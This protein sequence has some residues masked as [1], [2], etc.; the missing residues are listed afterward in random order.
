[1]DVMQ[2]KSCILY[3][4]YPIYRPYDR[5]G[6]RKTVQRRHLASKMEWL[7]Y[8]A[9]FNIWRQILRSFLSRYIYK[10]SMALIYSTYGPGY[11]CMLFHPLRMPILAGIWPFFGIWPPFSLIFFEKK[12]LRKYFLTGNP[13]LCTPNINTVIERTHYI[14]YCM[15]QFWNWDITRLFIWTTAKQQYWKNSK[16]LSNIGADHIKQLQGVHGYW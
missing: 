5:K 1:M 14:L 15:L 16:T 11:Q 7:L 10:T 9:G 8:V 3:L 6:L 2:L 12:C 13:T 4:I